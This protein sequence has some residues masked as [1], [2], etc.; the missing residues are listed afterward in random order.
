MLSSLFKENEVI[1]IFA[2][3][4][5]FVLNKENDIKKHKIPIL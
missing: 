4:S 1:E 2:M 5:A 3:I